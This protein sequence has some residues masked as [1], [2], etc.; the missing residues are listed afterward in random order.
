MRRLLPWLLV[1]TVVNAGVA[2]LLP[3]LVGPET[4]AV[5]L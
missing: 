3:L 2:A 4:L 1:F 5:D